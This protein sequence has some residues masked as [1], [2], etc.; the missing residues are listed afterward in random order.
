[1]AAQYSGKFTK[2]AVSFSAGVAATDDGGTDTTDDLTMATGAGAAITVGMAID[3]PNLATG[4]T[5]DAV[6]G[7]VITLSD[8]PTG[9]VSTTADAYAF[10]T[11]T[12]AT[13]G[14]AKYGKCYSM[15]THASVPTAGHPSTCG[16]DAYIAYDSAS[17]PH[18]TGAS[19]IDIGFCKSS[20]GNNE[21]GVAIPGGGYCAL[22]AAACDLDTA[23]KCTS[24]EEGSISFG[25]GVAK[26]STNCANQ[27]Y[28]IKSVSNYHGKMST[29]SLTAD[30]TTKCAAL[31]DSD[32]NAAPGTWKT[33]TDLVFV[34]VVS[35]VETFKPVGD[36]DNPGCKLDML[37]G[38]P[39]AGGSAIACTIP[40]PP[41][42]TDDGED[43]AAHGL[44]PIT[45]TGLLL[46]LLAT[47][48][49]AL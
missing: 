10:Y 9:T 5:V 41:A 44:V 49:A 30:D 18:T 27:D 28:C 16:S 35:S 37:V 14:L 46:L 26:T 48:G 19:D 20:T 24:A 32:G 29:I 38:E 33:F 1:M 12:G 2:T 7:D 13:C 47:L 17:Y 4:T 3:G 36:S 23:A 40:D 43:S 25:Y 8:A 15:S 21:A 22:S 45:A 31:T 39:C 11:V 34:D 42:A 6:A